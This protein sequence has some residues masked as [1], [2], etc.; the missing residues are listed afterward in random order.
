MPSSSKTKA[1][2]LIIDSRRGVQEM[3][4]ILRP[5]G[6]LLVL[7]DGDARGSWKAVLPEGR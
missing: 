2:V 7:P 5:A 1:P 3:S 4:G 6:A